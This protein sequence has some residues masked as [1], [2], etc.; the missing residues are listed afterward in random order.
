MFAHNIKIHVDT[1]VN[2]HLAKEIVSKPP[3]KLS[4]IRYIIYRHKLFDYETVKNN[5]TSNES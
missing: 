2:I 4:F 3:T 1:W 5:Q